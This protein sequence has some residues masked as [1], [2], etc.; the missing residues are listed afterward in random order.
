MFRA[1]FFF[2]SLWSLSI[3]NSHS[4]K[5]KNKLHLWSSVV[6]QIIY[7]SMTRFLLL[8]SCWINILICT[9]WHLPLL[10]LHFK[11]PKWGI[12]ILRM[13]IHCACLVFQLVFSFFTFL[14]TLD[15]PW[16]HY[17][18]AWTICCDRM[19]RRKGE[20]EESLSREY[21]CVTLYRVSGIGYL[22]VT[23]ALFS[24]EIVS[25]V[26]QSQPFFFPCH[27]IF[28]FFRYQHLYVI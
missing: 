14:R 7:F 17:S 28:R 16:R 10:F 3:G 20:G 2:F 1:I 15:S 27:V 5:K 11:T 19:G 22:S 21:L 4:C 9:L 8:L 12:P 18:K 6:Y 25:F 23:L 26:L 13:A 24:R